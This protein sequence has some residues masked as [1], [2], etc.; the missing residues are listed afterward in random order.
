MGKEASRQLLYPLKSDVLR[1]KAY[2]YKCTGEGRREGRSRGEGRGGERRGE[3]RREPGG[4]N[5]FGYFYERCIM[6][7]SVYHL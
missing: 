6:Y 1:T 5:N 3:D 4:R 7:Q 2:I